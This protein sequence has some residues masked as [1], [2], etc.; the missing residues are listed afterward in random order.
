[1]LS[2]TLI[3]E[4][5]HLIFLEHHSTGD[6]IVAALQLLRAVGE[7]GKPLSELSAMQVFPQKLINITVQS[8]PP[9]E[10]I[11]E[12]AAAI[13]QALKSPLG[14]AETPAGAWT[15]QATMHGFVDFNHLHRP[16]IG[17]SVRFSPSEGCGFRRR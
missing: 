17:Q 12:I 3:D 15:K 8:K 14:K 9:L 16:Y 10:E 4:S 5:G 7:Q 2:S 13:R 11:P 6:G 1:M